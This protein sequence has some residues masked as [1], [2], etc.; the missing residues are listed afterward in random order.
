MK[1]DHHSSKCTYRIW[2]ERQLELLADSAGWMGGAGKAPPCDCDGP[3][4]PEGFISPA[5]RWFMDKYPK[6]FIT[7]VIVAI[8]AGV[9][10]R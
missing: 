10:A 3:D 7:M 1:L 9:C 4:L 8:V 5:Q 6:T 2:Y